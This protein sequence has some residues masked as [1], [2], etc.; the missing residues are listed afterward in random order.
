MS[1]D[2]SVRA[3]GNHRVCVRRSEQIRSD[4]SISPWS[5]YLYQHL[6]VRAC[7]RAGSCMAWHAC[8][9]ADRSLPFADRTSTTRCWSPPEKLATTAWG[10]DLLA[11]PCM[12]LASCRLQRH[13]LGDAGKNASQYSTDAC[14]A[15]IGF[16]WLHA[17][18]MYAASRSL[19]IQ[20]WSL[21]NQDCTP[22]CSVYMSCIYR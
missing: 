20:K 16:D 11:R 7:V 17:A 4:G 19:Y 15:D 13:D 18:C 9:W 21:V 8:A 2:Q 3:R 5:V 14:N 12:H 1:I 10:F 6:R 22:Y